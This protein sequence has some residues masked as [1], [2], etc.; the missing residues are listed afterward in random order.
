MYFRDYGLAK[1]PFN[2]YLKNAVSQY[3]SKR[4]MVKA[5]KDFSN[6]DAGTFIILIDHRSGY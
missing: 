5:R 6:Y 3:L 4:N 2:K 1:R